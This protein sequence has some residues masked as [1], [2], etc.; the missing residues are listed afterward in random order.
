MIFISSFLDSSV[1]DLSR[2][3]VNHSDSHG[4]RAK[5][6]VF[7]NK[8]I[9]L[10]PLL[11]FIFLFTAGDAYGQ[12]SLNSGDGWGAGWGVGS[13]FSS[14]AGSSLIYVAT[15]SSGAGNRYFRFFGT[16]FPCGQYGPSGAVDVQLFSSTVYNSS[17]LTCGSSK[18]YYLAVSNNTDNWVFKSAGSTAQKM[19]I[20]RVQGTVR[21]IS[22]VS[23]NPA[24]PDYSQSA[25]ITATL[26]GNLAT[27]QGVYL[28]YTTN[29]FSTS[30]IVEMTGSST[31]YSASIPSQAVGSNVKYYVFTSGNGLAIPSGDADFYTINL[32]NNGGSN[33]SYSPTVATR[34]AVSSGNWNSS[35]VWSATSG[36]AS[37]ATV[38]GV[39]DIAIIPSGNTIT[40]TTNQS[41]GSIT[42]SGS[43][44]GTI[45][46][47]SNNTLSVSGTVTANSGTSA[48]IVGDGVLSFSGSNSI[49]GTASLNNVSINGGVN[50][51][52]ASTING[53][54]TINSGGFVSTNAPTYMS[55]SLLRYNTT[56]AYG[57]GLEWSATSGAGYPTHVQV[58]NNTT[59][60][61]NN[62]ANAARQIAGNLTVDV[63]STLSLE[64]MTIASPTV[65][66]LTVV[67]NVI[68]N[69]TV[70]L[71]TSTE[72]LKCAD[73]TNN[74]GATT[75][76]SSNVGGDLEITGSLIDNA[77]FNS[78]N[79][80]V[81]FTGTGLQ[82][83]SGTGTF[84]IDY[85]VSNKTSGSIRMLTNLLV[86]GPNGGNAIT[87]SNST[88]VLSLNGFALTIGKAN[89]S[90]TIS[91]SGAI[92][93]SS[94]SSLS[95]LGSGAF[96]TVNFDQSTPG[97]TNALG[98]LTIDR[99]TSGSVVLGNAV[100]VTNAITITNGN[101]DL[102]TAF[103]TAGS[104]TLGATAQGTGSSY[105]GT[106]SPAAT[107]N[108]TYFAATTGAVN[109]G[110]CSTYSITST[111]ATACLG[112]AATVT[113][114]NSTSA[115][116]PVGTYTVYYT[117]T[118]ANTGSSS[119]T[120]IVTAAGSGSFTTTAITNNGAT[121]L[122]INYL[123]N[124][125]VSA[126][127][128]GNTTSITVNELPTALTLTGGS[129]CPTTSASGAI[130]SSGSASGVS[131]QLWNTEGEV[132]NAN[133]SGSGSGLTWSNIVAGTGYYVLATNN[134]T[135][136]ISGSSNVVNVTLS[137]TN[138]AYSFYVD[139]DAD[140]YGTGTAVIGCSAT[141]P[142]GYSLIA[143]D[144]NNTNSAIYPT[145][146]E[147]CGNNIDENCSGASDDIPS[148]YRTIADGNW[149]DISTWEVACSSGV[150]YTAAAYAP[151][152]YYTGTVNIRDTHDVTI[153]IGA[154]TWQTGTLDIDFGGSLTLTGNDYLNAPT[155]N[156]T[157]NNIP[158]IA[159]LSVTLLI[160]NAGTLN[161]GHQASLVQTS[162]TASNTGS[163]NVNVESKLTGTANAANTAPNGR[164]WY[165]GSPMNNTSAGQFFDVQNM[166]RLWSYNGSNNSWGVVV[167]S[168]S[169]PTVTTTNKLVPGIGYLY[170]GGAN[171]TITY[172]GTAAA[173]L[174]NNI[175][176]N[177]LN[178][179][180][181]GTLVNVLGYQS[182]GYK[183]VANPY[184]SHI[185]WRLVTRSGLNVSYWIR[186]ANNSAYDAYNATTNVSTG[187]S[188][189]TTRFIPP[190]QG[191]YVFAFN[192]TPSLRID[193]TDRVHSSNVLH[194]PT[195]NQVVRLRLNNGESSDYTV[196]YENEVAANDYEEADTDKMFDYDF[197][198]LY[199]LEGE[200][201]LSLNGLLNATSKGSVDMGIAVPNN[202]A[203][204]IE[205]TDLEVEEEVILEDKFT[206]TF[207]D[208]KVNPIYSF[209]SNA[210]TFNERFVL[211][212]TTTE[213]VGVG[214]TVVE[215]EG[216]NVFTTTGQ[217]VKVWV[218][219][220][221]EFQNA[222]VKVYD[223]IG[224]L[225]ERKNMTSNE[226]LLDLNTATGVYLV[227]VTG[228]SKVFTKKIFVTK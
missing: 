42:F 40:C 163:G 202:G 168:T 154:T 48:S 158:A 82:D 38:P 222:T 204:T 125:C 126:T 197:H 14:S 176:S 136:C 165:I 159:K 186:N 127:S 45:S 115:L 16:G 119:S 120:M 95:I 58:S 214:E 37:G 13:S 225:V 172:V 167:H 29:D 67:G 139:S 145:A 90:S 19:I 59:L 208:L 117:L 185:D 203:Y 178:P 73:F 183:F 211:H 213:T 160:D 146:T 91:G 30:T 87:L 36:G 57:R 216:V 188:G 69:G 175:T 196:V 81:F 148:Y 219:N 182:T 180:L 131:Y 162:T 130:T 92:R 4:I 218:T 84:N 124:G 49:S 93:G 51:G 195:V 76:L 201:E 83:V 23:M 31:T 64:G 89:V 121:A 46:I 105:G 227:E 35:A 174:N 114:S 190:M 155:S 5:I 228:D 150:T 205:A 161:I 181:D 137:A 80:A 22:S 55:S 12:N 142:A 138:S 200:H 107:V 85:I 169:N 141:L 171:K 97:T 17:T 53:T 88:D 147:I 217:Q 199:T 11:V 223:A 109:V 132:S 220:T 170:R 157:T 63:G 62:G 110:S 72:R 25:T 106:G 116:L 153:P 164:Y 135:N 212:F 193:N 75:A 108:S 47:G 79:R 61:V 26:S 101:V 112:S 66:G 152:T 173:N 128:S 123:R 18:A 9:L 189:Q 104:L 187:L 24:T 56:G 191:F 27:G 100:A 96:G 34:Y 207:Q 113:L 74:A 122:T 39:G 156:S 102:G 151:P 15:N 221:A 133:I 149:G 32:N 6:D 111:S 224:N 198:Q 78:S 86:E 134:T 118:G 1:N 54:L 70:T 179:T 44:T 41:V 10:L 99:T 206:N 194:A 2:G 43:G 8:R 3:S 192:S 71:A 210:G 21:T 77:T 129:Y 33:Y 60:N 166:V 98:S 20:F 52:A 184:P 177:L 215:L 7:I 226:L 103:H 140:G 144:C 94:S 28:R 65:I 50:F 209:T 143:G 68:N